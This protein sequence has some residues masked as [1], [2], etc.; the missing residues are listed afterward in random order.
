MFGKRG[1]MNWNKM[2]DSMILDMLKG[3]EGKGKSNLAVNNA[4][5]NIIISLN[6]LFLFIQL[7]L[8]NL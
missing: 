6:Q 5:I 1:K 4:Y 3:R 8:Y 2:N 7:N